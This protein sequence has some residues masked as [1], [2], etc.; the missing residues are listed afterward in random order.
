MSTA[1][2]PVF[3]AFLRNGAEMFIAARLAPT[4]AEHMVEYLRLADLPTAPAV[5]DMGAGCGAFGA[6][7][8]AAVPGASVINVVND[9]ALVA[10]IRANGR[11]C[12]E[13]SFEDTPLPDGIADVVTF[14]EAIGHGDLGRAMAEAARV[15]K[16]GGLLVIKDFTPTDPSV[17]AVELPEWGYC[18]HEVGAYSRC[19]DAAGLVFERALHPTMHLQHWFDIIQKEPAA[20]DSAQRHP[21]EQLRIGMVLFTFRKAHTQ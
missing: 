18:V 17:A 3:D 16:P 1:L 2:A 4:E 12:I 19:A 7:V 6:W 5:V 10:Y 9:P 11:A 14:N 13:S 21:P 20:K 8:E 15:L